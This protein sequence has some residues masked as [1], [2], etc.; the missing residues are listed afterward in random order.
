VTVAGETDEKRW[1]A[2][3]AKGRRGGGEKFDF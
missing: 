2:T 1:Q 3:S